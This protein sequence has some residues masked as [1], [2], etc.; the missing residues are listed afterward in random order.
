MDAASSWPYLLKPVS[1]AIPR[2]EQ[3]ANGSVGSS[4]GELVAPD[5][6]AQDVAIWPDRTAYV[7]TDLSAEQALCPTKGPRM[8]FS[9]EFRESQS[10][11]TT[12]AAKLR[13]RRP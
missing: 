8:R 7:A 9:I 11:R 6:V 5:I 1:H 12:K 2:T 13:I 3:C 10:E 4:D